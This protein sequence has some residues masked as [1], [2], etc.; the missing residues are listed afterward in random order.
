MDGARSLLTIH[1]RNPQRQSS[2]LF[3]SVRNHAIPAGSKTVLVRF[4]FRQEMYTKWS[5]EELSV[6]LGGT[7]LTQ[8]D[9][10][11]IE[12]NSQVTFCRG[13]LVHSL[14]QTPALSQSLV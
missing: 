11:K 6:Q 1:F 5:P 12:R 7:G 9:I 8:V 14:S 10:D 13:G 4:N 3:A 2:K